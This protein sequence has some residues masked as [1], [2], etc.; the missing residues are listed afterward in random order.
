MRTIDLH[1]L[2]DLKAVYIADVA[3]GGDGHHLVPYDGL[4]APSRIHVPRLPS[5]AFEGAFE[6][7]RCRAGSLDIIDLL[8]LQ[9]AQHGPVAAHGASASGA[10][11]GGLRLVRGVLARARHG[12]IEDDPVA[13][14]NR[15]DRGYLKLIGAVR[16]PGAHRAIHAKLALVLPP[17]R[18]DDEPRHMS[19][20]SSNAM[21]PVPPVSDTVL[22]PGRSAG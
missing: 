2:L 6:R 14:L 11:A 19:H 8:E 5:R 22:H 18:I 10:L 21:V 3:D 1:A 12:V 20:I 9:V 16:G 15:L 7:L 13:L 4:R 17:S